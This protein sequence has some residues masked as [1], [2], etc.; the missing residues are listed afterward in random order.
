MS[1][2][3][4]FWR[5]IKTERSPVPMMAPPPLSPS[6]PPR[7]PAVKPVPK[8]KP[9]PEPDLPPLVQ[10]GRVR[11]VPMDAIELIRAYEGLRLEPYRDAAGFWT[12]GYGHLISRNRKAPRPQPITRAQAEELLLID[13]EREAGHVLR[14][15]KVP[16]KDG[17]YGALVSFTFN[18]GGGAL[19]ASTLLRFVNQERHSEVPAQFMRWVHAGGRRLNGLVRRR[20]AEAAMY[21]AEL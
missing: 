21:E 4:R 13:I 15:V 2:F 16:L 10:V 6:P 9:I 18:L 17:Q 11:P 20:K 14:N 8:A 7:R 3:R 1:W 19:K 12:I 5:A